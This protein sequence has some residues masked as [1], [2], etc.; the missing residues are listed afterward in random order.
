MPA[1]IEVFGRLGEKFLMLLREMAEMAHVLRGWPRWYFWD[2]WATRIAACLAEGN[3]LKLA[4]LRTLY[5]Q[6]RTRDAVEQTAADTDLWDH[7]IDLTGPAEAA[8][9]RATLRQPKRSQRLWLRRPGTGTATQTRAKSHM[10]SLREE[11]AAGAGPAHSWR[12]RKDDENN[13]GGGAAQ[14]RGSHRSK[15]R[16]ARRLRSTRGRV[17]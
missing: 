13:W 12:R 15:K 8:R 17:P 11:T 9:R 2:K 14:R 3:H 1:A 10:R 7:T 16:R 4:N 5:G 6:R